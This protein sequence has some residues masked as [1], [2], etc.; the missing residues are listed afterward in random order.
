MKKTK[1]IFNKYEMT[2][3]RFWALIEEASWPSFGYDRSKLSY[4]LSLKAKEGKAF[5]E[6]VSELFDVLDKF[7]DGRYDGLNVGDDGYSDLLYHII[8]MGKDAYYEHLN[9][10]SKIK[11]RANA[12]YGSAEGYKESFSYAIPYPSEWDNQSNAIKEVEEDIKRKEKAKVK[13]SP[14]KLGENE[15]LIN[16]DA[17]MENI[18]ESLGNAEGCF[19]AEIHNRVCD[20]PIKYVEDSVWTDA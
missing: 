6:V 12:P 4:L 3:E 19:V 5:S 15:V 7:V 1:A 14:S 16:F 9:S 13:K 11:A 8:G 20:E 17:I 2:E 10:Y 18:R